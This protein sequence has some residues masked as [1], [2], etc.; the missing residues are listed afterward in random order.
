[1]DGPAALHIAELCGAGGN[2]RRDLIDVAAAVGIGGAQRGDRFGHGVG[3]LALGCLI[4]RLAHDAHL[5]LHGGFIHRLH[6]GEAFLAIARFHDIANLV[7][8]VVLDDG[9]VDRLHDG[10]PLFT[11]RCLPHR[12]LHGVAALGG[13]RLPHRLADGVVAGV[14]DRFVGHDRGGH[15]LLVI[16]SLEIET[17]GLRGH[18]RRCR[19]RG[20]TAALGEDRCRHQVGQ[21]RCRAQQRLGRGGGKT[22]RATR[23]Q[24][25]HGFS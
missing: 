22:Q 11:R 4:H 21:H 6:D 10:E 18:R 23:E 2:H 3:F 9:F 5:L 16:D 17:V 13:L 14:V 24:G 25:H 8:A 20:L 19:C 12:T 15:L 1:M 7:V